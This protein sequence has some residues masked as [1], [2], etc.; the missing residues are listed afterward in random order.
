MKIN[1]LLL[2]LACLIMFY[3][4][5]AVNHHLDSV[6][7]SSQTVLKIRQEYERLYLGQKKE[8][9]LKDFGKPTIKYGAGKSGINYEEEW[10][11]VTSGSAW[12][13]PAGSAVWFYVNDGV[14]KDINVW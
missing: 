7:K 9:L 6:N 10:S 3:G 12:N 13:A 11:Y 4:C 5:G 8:I 2:P 1:L 14:I